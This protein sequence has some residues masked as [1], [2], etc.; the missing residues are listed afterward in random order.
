MSDPS[1]LQDTEKKRNCS[2][3]Y[4]AHLRPLWR[5]F[6][7]LLTAIQLHQPKPV[8]FQPC[9]LSFTWSHH[10][11][12]VSS[13]FSPQSENWWLGWRCNY[14]GKCLA[15][16]GNKT[17]KARV[18]P[19]LSPPNPGSLL[20]QWLSAAAG[21]PLCITDLVHSHYVLYFLRATASLLVLFPF[22]IQELP[23]SI[24]QSGQ[25]SHP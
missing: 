17:Q 10:V 24:P 9:S 13:P 6:P 1:V 8:V 15:K 12:S 22:Y 23:L 16:S 3:Q 25:P 18:K 11:L 5:G 4:S 20:Q 7:L 19:I 2:L 21:T 14:I